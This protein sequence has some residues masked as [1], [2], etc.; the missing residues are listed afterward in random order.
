MIYQNNNGF[1]VFLYKAEWNITEGIRWQYITDKE[2]FEQ[3]LL[4]QM[5][6]EQKSKNELL[7]MNNENPIETPI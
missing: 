1:F 4:R 2:Q 6:R 5:E 7:K 3:D